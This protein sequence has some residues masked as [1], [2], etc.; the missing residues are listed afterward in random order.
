MILNASRPVVAFVDES[1]KYVKAD[2][3]SSFYVLA[4]VLVEGAALSST[5]QALRTVVAPLTEFHTNELNA[6]GRQDVVHDV[7]S[8]A[9][10]E[11]SGSVVTVQMP[12]PRTEKDARRACLDVLLRDLSSRKVS[13]VVADSRPQPR[14]RDRLF[15]DKQDEAVARRLRASGDVDRGLNLVHRKPAGE[16]LLWLAD[17]V[18]WALRRD[19]AVD[20]TEHF[21]IVKP[22][23]SMLLIDDHGK[24]IN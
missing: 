21:R 6:I 9:R 1:Y 15:L 5:R 14:A 19:L 20:D 17:A 8:F 10:D 22:V 4:A 12:F 18:A 2:L 24:K 16:N 3:G 7:L 23:T 13:Q 11:V